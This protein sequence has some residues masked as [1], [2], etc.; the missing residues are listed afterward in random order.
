MR[1]ASLFS[2]LGAA[3]LAAKWMGW[4]NIFHCEINPFCLKTLEYWFPESKEYENI[5]DTDFRQWRG[6]VDVLTGGFP[7]Q[8]FSQAGKRRGNNDDRYLWPEMLRAIREIQPSWIVGENVNGITNMVES[9]EEIEVGRSDDIFDE[10]FIYRKEEKFTIWRICEDLEQAGYWVQPVIIPACAVG[11]PHRRNRVWF[12]ATSKDTNRFRCNG[13]TDSE[14]KPHTG[15][16]GK[17]CTGDNGRTCFSSDSERCGS[18]AL[19]KEVERKQPDGERTDGKGNKQFASHSEGS[20]KRRKLFSRQETQKP[21]RQ[22]SGN[23]QSRWE[24]FPTQPP[25][26]RGND[27]IPFNVDDLTIP[28]KEWREESI[29]GYG[30]AWVPQVAFEIF[31][32]IEKL[33]K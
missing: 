20:G 12:I 21:F 17:S 7:C 10:S 18:N 3:E 8:P 31:K 27:G 26:C 33:S 13:K 28:F 29:K 2:G 11:A 24:G 19:L 16:Y 5:K 1:H 9:V 22:N 25:I 15:E 32:I 23:I 30:N 4:E 6:K 14:D